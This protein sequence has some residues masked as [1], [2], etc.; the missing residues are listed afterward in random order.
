MLLLMLFTRCVVNNMFLVDIFFQMNNLSALLF[1]DV[2]NVSSTVYELFD[3]FA[4]CR[5]K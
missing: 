4:D 5:S 3:M 1:V 2:W